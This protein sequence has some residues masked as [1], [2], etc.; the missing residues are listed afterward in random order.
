MTP[1]AKQEALK[2]GI[3]YDPL[4]LEHDTGPGHPESPERL[5]AIMQALNEPDVRD[6]LA[7]IPAR[8][9][10]REE[11][12]L[13][14]TSDY[15]ETAQRE[16]ESGLSMLTTGDTD[17]CGRSFDVALLAAG[18]VLNATD[19]VIDKRVKNAFCAVRPPGHHATTDAGMGFCLFNNVA[20]AARYAQQK[21]GLARALIVDWDVHHGNGTQDIF[22]AD[23]RVL[24]FSTHQWPWYPG[25]GRA[26]EI[27]QGLGKGRTINAPL[28]AGSSA[29]DVFAEFRDGLLPASAS[30][31]PDIVFI[32]AGFDSHIGDPLGN[33]GLSDSDFAEL[34][35]MVMTIADQYA[36]GRIVS[37][38]EGG[39]NLATLASA[40]KAHV[41]ILAS[42]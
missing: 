22:Y 33:I 15:I 17:V 41:K 19:A 8:K 14:H 12:L 13:C 23:D 37:V 1:G 11:L 42:D 31:D 27:G 21:H 18:G 30:F 34:T 5:N 16:V 24:Y 32:S 7:P 26:V 29:S 3:L 2:T 36:G 39:Y 9:A 10:S 38:L 4:Y 25:S 28:A 20:I 40:V 35:T 6:L